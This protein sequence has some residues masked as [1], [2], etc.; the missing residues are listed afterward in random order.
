MKKLQAAMEYLMTYGWAILII[1]L[2]LGVLYSLGVLNPSRLKPVVCQLPAPFTCSNPTANTGGV[3]TITLG[4][5]SGQTITIN[6]VA[7][8]DNSLID[9]STGLPKS[10][11]W[12]TLSNP[13]TIGSGGTI[14]LSNIQCYASDENPWSGP[15]GSVFGGS[16]IIN[17]AMGSSNTPYYTAGSI[18]V[19]VTQV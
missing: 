3:V 17:Y 16:L 8:V 14:T 2:A 19:Q 11:G 7:C 4:Q 15:I 1:A 13:V 9:P 10:V 18:S 6:G 12:T 5:G